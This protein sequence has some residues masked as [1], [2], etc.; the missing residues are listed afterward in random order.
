MS[1]WKPSDLHD[2]DALNRRGQG[3]EEFARGGAAGEARE[4]LVERKSSVETVRRWVQESTGEI[5]WSWPQDRRLIGERIERVDGPIKTTGE[6]RYAFDV[7]RP[8][9]CTGKFV[10][11]P[12]ARARI[13]SIDTG[14]AEAADGVVAVHV[15]KSADEIVGYHG[16]PVVAVAAE[17]ERQARDAARAVRVE[18]EVLPHVV[19]EE[20]A[21]APG[22][23]EIVE[24]GNVREG[25]AVERGDVDAGFADAATIYEGEFRTQVETHCSLET[26]GLVAEWDGDRLTVWASTQGV[27][28]TRGGLAGYFDVPEDRVRVITPVMGGGFGSKFGPDVQGVVAAELARKAE[29][30]VKLMLER[31][32]EQLDSGNRPSSVAAVKAGAD[33][34]G[35][36]VAFECDTYGTGG[37][38]AG[39]NFPLP[40]IYER[41]HDIPVR[42]T[43]RNVYINAGSA[44]AMRAP[45]H[46]QAAFIMDSVMDELADRLEIDPIEFRKRNLPAD[47]LW[48]EQLDRAAEEIGWEDR[49]PPGDPTPGPVKSGLGAA[50]CVWGGGGRGTQANCVIGPDGSVEM[51]IGTQDI[52]TGTRTLVAMVTAE[53]LGLPLD[54]VTPKIGDTAY[55]PSG[56]SGGSTTAA[57]VCPAAR[58]AAGRALNAIFEAVAPELGA[59][60]SELEAVEGTI[61]VAGDAGRSMPWSD[62]CAG[63]VRSRGA[64]GPVEIHGEWQEGLSSSGVN[65]AQVAEVSVDTE[66]G[67][68]TVD[69]IVAYQ[70]CGMIVNLLTAESQ[71]YG[72]VIMGIGFALFEDRILDGASGRMLNP[73]LE[74]YGLPG[75][76]DIPDI[77][78]RM[79]DTPERGV[80]GLGEP[81]AI[82]TAGAIANAVSNAIGVRIRSLPITPEKVL[83]ALEEGPE[84]TMRPARFTGARGAPPDGGG[85]AVTATPDRPSGEEVAR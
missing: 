67:V 46:P 17:T 41:T 45:G 53:I 51:R 28:A 44:R 15:I 52:G 39:A 58:V 61:R 23:P 18:Y 14:P 10:R 42:R 73:N 25:N 32:E 40:Y 55:P 35:R 66:T 82:P 47:S 48:Q 79:M 72:G 54:A 27:Y 65:G 69:R 30:P 68:V 56:A 9:M 8:G 77:T 84:A 12:H 20:Q 6:A 70:D 81:P 5:E 19:T 75:P 74:F 85:A 64:A 38:D 50:I 80:I 2:V 1:E 60:A 36:L 83:A 43:H 62:A 33:A 24:G 7:N 13:V 31:D 29:R 49:H 37:I 16:D 26:H 4:R 21:M 57:S 78:V 22:A 71:V 63:L 59:P 3:L 76:S 11:S 34:E